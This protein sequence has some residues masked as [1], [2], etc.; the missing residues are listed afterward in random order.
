[1][2]WGRVCRLCGYDGLEAHSSNYNIRLT[3]VPEPPRL[4]RD[5]E[6]YSIGKPK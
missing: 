5:R 4:S 6:V 2:S 1:M 3:D